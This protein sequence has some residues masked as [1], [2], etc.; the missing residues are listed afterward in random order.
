MK[1]GFCFLEYEDDLAAEDA[2]RGALFCRFNGALNQ[3]EPTFCCNHLEIAAM[4]SAEFMGRR[5]R[6]EFSRPKPTF[7]GAG[8]GGGG[9]LDRQP[10][11][12]GNC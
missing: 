8:G 12:V 6:V 1:T 3:R 11:H 10:R 2:Q 5:L 7:D 9:E 4:D